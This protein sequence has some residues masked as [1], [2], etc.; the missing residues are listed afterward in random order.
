MSR[1]NPSSRSASSQ[2]VEEKVCIFFSSCSMPKRGLSRSRSSR[3]LKP[4]FLAKYLHQVL[5]PKHLALGRLPISPNAASNII[6]FTIA[7]QDSSQVTTTFNA[8]YTV[9]TVQ[10]EISTQICKSRC[11]VG[12]VPYHTV[13]MISRVGAQHPGLWNCD[14]GCSVGTIK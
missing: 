5:T 9:H 13:C 4:I 14:W 11:K 12:I 2:K 6:H 8:Q 7:S 10:L 3:H 1:K